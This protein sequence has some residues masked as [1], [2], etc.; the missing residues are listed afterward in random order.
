LA[1]G[2]I[3]ARAA[4]GQ[5]G[6]GNAGLGEDRFEVALARIAVEEDGTGPS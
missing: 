4:D 1:E 6:D 5:A 3:G 2:G